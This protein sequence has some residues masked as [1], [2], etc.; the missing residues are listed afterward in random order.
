MTTQGHDPIVL[1]WDRVPSVPAIPARAPSP[2][3]LIVPITPKV[4]FEVP[5]QTTLEV[6]SQVAITTA[7]PVALHV[8]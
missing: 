5:L 4:T 3:I 2:K 8:E 6:F 1:N 7:L